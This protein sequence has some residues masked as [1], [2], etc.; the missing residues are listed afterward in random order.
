MAKAWDAEKRS[1][2]PRRPP[3]P[4]PPRLA[5]EFFSGFWSKT[6]ELWGPAAPAGVSK[7]ARRNRKSLCK[8]PLLNPL[9]SRSP[10]G[11]S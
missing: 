11:P 6:L 5:S 10:G 4:G 3:L 8:G 7:P 2:A 1:E 9:K